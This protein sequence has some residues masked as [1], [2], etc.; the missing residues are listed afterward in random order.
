MKVL[1][2]EETFTSLKD[3]GGLPPFRKKTFQIMMIRHRIEMAYVRTLLKKE[4][5]IPL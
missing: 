2:P 1:Y 5:S 4:R 3:G